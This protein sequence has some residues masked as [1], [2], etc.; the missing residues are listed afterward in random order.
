MATSTVW[1]ASGALLAGAVTFVPVA[2][3]AGAQVAIKRSPSGFNL[4]TAQQDVEIGR[5][6]A[7][8]IERQVTLVTSARTTQYL[9]AIASLLGAQVATPYPFQVRAINSGE[10]NVLA[11]PGGQIFVTRG[12]LALA[13]NEAEVAGVL[14]H[15]MAHVALRHGTARA[16]RA[17]LSKAGLS[18]LGGLGGDS[19]TRRIITATGGYGVK[20]V[21]LRFTGTDEYEADALG[22]EVMSKAGYDPVASAALLATLRREKSRLP[23]IERFNNA[24]PPL[25]DRESRIR[26]LSNVLRHGRSEMV[27]GFASMRWSMPSIAAV[28]PAPE[29]KVSTGAVEL[30]ATAALPNVPAPSSQFTRFSNP[31]APIEIDHPSNWDAHQSGMAM[32]F[33]PSGGVVE[34]EDG[35]PSLLQGMIVNY[36]EPFEGDVERWNKSLERSYAPFEDRSRPRGVLED[37]TDDL[38]R[39]IIDANA[40]LTAPA[41]S[42]RSQQVD[43]MR[44]YTVRLRGRSPMTGEMER[45]T[46]YTR[47]LPDDHIV[48]L[49]CVAGGRT[50]ASVERACSRMLQ[51]LR[52]NEEPLHRSLQR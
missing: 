2:P 8:E 5:Q 46:V 44:G 39:Q 18:A 51:S 9:A 14:A 33:V 27:G 16:S 17:Y 35:A 49:A 34:T 20:A 47:A 12:L 6:S 4:F 41:R 50:A 36:Y 31:D 23:A 30:R 11:L 45:V 25:A 10:V 28:P 26:N 37:A 7:L 32:S 22:A 29:V 3:V 24:H 15:A 19:A 38:V 40:W 1:T 43:G 52:I 42:A 13:R 21:F 48:Y